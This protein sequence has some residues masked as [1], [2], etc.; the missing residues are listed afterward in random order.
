MFSLCH[1]DFVYLLTLNDVINSGNILNILMVG[2]L[3]FD[4][5]SILLHAC[6]D[7]I[8]HLTIINDYNFITRLPSLISVLTNIICRVNFNHY[9]ICFYRVYTRFLPFTIVKPIRCFSLVQSVKS[10]IKS[11]YKKHFTISQPILGIFVLI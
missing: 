4:Y 8:C 1:R 3:L 7:F 6:V 9:V 10:V 2:V 5:Q 11:V